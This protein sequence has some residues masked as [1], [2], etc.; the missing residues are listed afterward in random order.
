MGK[1]CVFSLFP[2]KL[3]QIKSHGALVL[4]S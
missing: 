4:W 1:V 2:N 3:I